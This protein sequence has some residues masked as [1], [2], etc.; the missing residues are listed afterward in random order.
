MHLENAF[1]KVV[2]SIRDEVLGRGILDSLLLACLPMLKVL[3]VLITDPRFPIIS[4]PAYRQ[5]WGMGK[6]K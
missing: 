5:L 4:P 1:F 6:E 3:L 2:V